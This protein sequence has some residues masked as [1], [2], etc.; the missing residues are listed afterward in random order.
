[1][2]PAQLSNYLSANKARLID[3]DTYFV[4]G[5]RRYSAVMISN[6][7][8]DQK[9]WWWY[10]NVSPSQINTL[11]WSNKARL[12]DIEQHDPA[13][14]TFTVVMEQCPCPYWWWY[15]GVGESQ[16][17]DLLAQNGARIINIE[18]YSVGGQK[19]FA[20]IMINNSNAVTTRVSQILRSGADGATGLYL[21]QVGG[22]VLAALQENKI[23]E[24]AS[25][26]KVDPLLYAM[27]Q[28]QAG[29]ASLT[30]Q[31]PIY[32]D[33]AG[34][35][36]GA[37]TA[38]K[39]PLRDALQKM[40]QFSDNERTRA[41][42]ETFGVQNINNMAQ[43]IGLTSTRINHSPGCGGPTPNTLTLANAGLLYEGV[44]NGSL[45]NP[46]NRGTFFS[47]MAGKD[48]VDFSGAWDKTKE[49]ID[50]EAP[51][52]MTVAKKENFKNQIRMS[53]K[54]GGYTLPGGNPWFEHRSIAG[55]AQIPFCTGSVVAPRQYVFGIFIDRATNAAAADATWNNAKV[56]LLREP[57]RS[58]LSNWASCG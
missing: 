38:N 29:S 32:G 24:P 33:V 42:I 11:L 54:A 51:A 17:G 8:A 2:T 36:P 12:V 25:T 49:I 46:T 57:I 7:G 28:V 23:F 26:L 5:Q 52:G 35:C 43:A 31:V 13:A 58:A 34:S 19:R 53:Y 30:G 6:T 44:A 47:L 15:Y 10:Y 20:A 55:W 3:L 27:R 56:E 45:L 18:P 21:K 39:E 48:T 37:V 14:G 4:G 1:M 22:P 50:A 40:M 9:A 16:L 41:I